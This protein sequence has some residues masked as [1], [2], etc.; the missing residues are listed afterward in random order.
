MPRIFSLSLMG[1][2]MITQE[3]LRYACICYLVHSAVNNGFL[4][5]SED[6]LII[7][8]G[9]PNTREHKISHLFSI[10]IKGNFVLPDFIGHQNL[11]KYNFK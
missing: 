8:N 1:F 7:N 3:L 5:T 6:P 2:K 9:F 11:V 10:I 4:Y